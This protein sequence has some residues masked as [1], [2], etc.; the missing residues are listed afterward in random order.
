VPWRSK[1]PLLTGHTRRA[2]SDDEIK[3]AISILKR[4]KL[5]GDDGIL[6]EYF[7]EF[8]DYLL[9]VM[10]NFFNCISDTGIFPRTWTSSIIISVYKKVQGVPKHMLHF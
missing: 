10:H 4:G 6:N 7:V 3:E 9:T 1:H 5:Y 8:Y 2:I